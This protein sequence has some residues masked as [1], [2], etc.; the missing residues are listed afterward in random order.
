[1]RSPRPAWWLLY[2][3]FPLAIVLLVAA[4]LASPSVGWREVAEGTASLAIMGAMASWVRA[5]RVAL[6]SGDDEEDPKEMAGIQD[7]AWLDSL[8]ID[9]IEQE[10]DSHQ[11]IFPE[12]RMGKRS[13]TPP[14]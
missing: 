14:V 2:A 3:F 13:R 8:G 9:P 1:M 7:R 6:A 10:A 11:D 5:N 12:G 4:H